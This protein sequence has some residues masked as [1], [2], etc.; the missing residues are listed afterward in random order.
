MHTISLAFSPCPNDTF[1]FDALVSQKIDTEGIS[2]SVHLADVEKLNSKALNSHF[3]CTKISFH[4]FAY[5]FKQYSLLE[6]GGALGYGNGPVFICKKET[7]SEI[8]HLSKIAL[9]GKHTTAHL[10]FSIAY[11]EYTNKEFMI[12]SDIEHAILHDVV[13]AG[14]IIHE[15]RFTYQNKG[16]VCI[17]DLGNFWE[18]KT[19]TPIPLG[20]I[21][22]K[23]SIPHEIAKK[24][25]KAIKKS[26][27]YAYLHNSQSAP[28]VVNNAQDMSQDIIN[29][30]IS[31]FVNDY[32]L[33]YNTTGKQAISQLFSLA[34]KANV[35]PHVPKE[36]IF[37]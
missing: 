20:A 32:S 27:E 26:I 35:I 6:S 33:A 18:Q 24:V 34:H 36:S 13:D 2:Y 16:L 5:I 30:H 9:P 7:L 15:N 23:K 10:L 1:I 29:K 37:V 8:S 11:P 3:D 17:R 28:F 4:A 14:V 12:F 21:A 25:E 22:I 19:N 31:L